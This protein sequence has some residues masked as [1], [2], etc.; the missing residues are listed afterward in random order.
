MAP[1]RPKSDSIERSPIRVTTAP[2]MTASTIEWVAICF[3]LFVSPA[4]M[5]LDKTEEVPVPRPITMPAATNHTGN[6]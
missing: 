2:A 4:P 1:R 3:T 6:A 5:N